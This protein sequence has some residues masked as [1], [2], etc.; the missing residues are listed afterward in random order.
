M[1]YIDD[2]QEEDTDTVGPL[3]LNPSQATAT[4]N[5]SIFTKLRNGNIFERSITSEGSINNNK[6]TS[7]FSSLFSSSSNNNN[8]NNNN[9]S[10][11]L[12][13]NCSPTTTE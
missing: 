7:I 10:S 9:A 3:A 5:V 2:E 8:N 13:R 6:R 12:N 11:V 1:H 4:T